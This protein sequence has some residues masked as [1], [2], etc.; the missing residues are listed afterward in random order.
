MTNNDNRLLNTALVGGGIVGIFITMTRATL[1]GVTIA[2]VLVLFHQ[3][4]KR[5]TLI[6]PIVIVGIVLLFII[7]I[8]FFI[9][10]TMENR[11]KVF[12]EMLNIG[13]KILVGMGPG[14]FDQINPLNLNVHSTPLQLLTD[15]GV[16][17]ALSYIMIV[18]IITFLL[19]RHAK[20]SNNSL[21]TSNSIFWTPSSIKS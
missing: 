13:S 15:F 8:I 1:L 6:R 16:L 19:W 4:V 3:L 17:G 7:S 9:D 18:C 2:I 5:F 11:L 21:V 10:I 20:L 14:K 12:Q